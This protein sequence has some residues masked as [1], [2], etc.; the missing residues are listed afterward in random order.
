M[1]KHSRNLVWMDLE[2]SGLDPEKDVILEIATIVTDGDLN[3]LAEGP[4]IAIHQNENVFEGMDEWNT[5]HHNASGLVDRCRHSRYSLAD[6]EQETLRF[7][8]PFTE[9]TKN[10]LCGNS[11]TQDR[12]FLYKYM[13]EISNWLCYRNIDVSSIKE[14]TFRWYPKLAEFQKDKCHE[15]LSDIRESIAELAY[16]RKTIFK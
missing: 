11:I 5:K 13:P 6:A 14:L 4:V 3:V 9:K 12:R 2:M 7:I 8:K 1:A 16:Y 10:V 15:A